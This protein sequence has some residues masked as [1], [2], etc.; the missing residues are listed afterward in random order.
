MKLLV[1]ILVSTLAL[2]L[3]LLLMMREDPPDPA[4]SNERVEPVPQGLEPRVAALEARVTELEENVFLRASPLVSEPPK[5]EPPAVDLRLSERIARL[6]GEL[7]SLRTSYEVEEAGSHQPEER[8]YRDEWTRRALDL[9]S[10]PEEVLQAL[11]AL[12]GERLPDGTDARI[13]ILPAVLPLAETSEDPA[14]RADAWRQLHGCD[15]PSLLAPLLRAHESDP[16][17]RVREEAA[18][19]LDAFL[20]DALVA[21]ALRFAAENDPDP[22]VRRQALESLA[23]GERK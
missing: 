23:G 20:A 21:Q 22:G 8:P 2:G 15:D 11:G 10:T 12:R 16:V 6:E 19:S 9:T 17:A 5:E 4:P 3:G 13:A 1:L 7:E 18:E 14:V